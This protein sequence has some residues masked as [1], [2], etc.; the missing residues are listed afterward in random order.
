MNYNF[1]S[2]GLENGF[3]AINPDRPWHGLY[4]DRRGK[5]MPGKRF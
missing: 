1:R 2:E 5:A 3:Y 4:D